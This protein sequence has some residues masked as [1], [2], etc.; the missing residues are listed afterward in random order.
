MDDVSVGIDDAGAGQKTKMAALPA[1][2]FPPPPHSPW[3]GHE[4][5][6]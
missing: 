4:A 2:A 3:F 6:E 1:G 5:Y